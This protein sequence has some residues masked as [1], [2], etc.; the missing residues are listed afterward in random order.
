[1]LIQTNQD[2]QFVP[3]RTKDIDTFV[4]DH[5]DS[6]NQDKIDVLREAMNRFDET[7]DEIKQ[8]FRRPDTSAVL[9]IR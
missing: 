6:V 4:S 5:S 8:H 7:F 9:S 3:F 1:M 2:Q